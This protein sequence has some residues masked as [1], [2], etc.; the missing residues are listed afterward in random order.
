[1]R[2]L[3]SIAF[4]A[5]LFTAL[6]GAVAH[7]SAL[8]QVTWQVDLTYSFTQQEVSQPD[9][10]QRQQELLG[11][12]STRLSSR[13]AHLAVRRSA[14]ADQGIDDAFHIEGQGTM[15]QFKLAMFDD[16]SL[17]GGFLGGP[18]VMDLTGQVS[19]G[20][21]V[22][23]ALDSN[24]S[25]GYG[26][27]VSQIDPS[28]LQE[29]APPALT[30]ETNLLGAPLRESITVDALQDGSTGLT[31][32]YGRPWETSSSSVRHVSLQSAQLDALTD[33]TNPTPPAHIAMPV[34]SP[35]HAPVVSAPQTLPA[36]FDWR[37]QSTLPPVRDQGS[38]GACWAF[39]TVG[40]METNMAIKTGSSADLSEQYLVSC[41]RDGWGCG[42]GWWA[43]DYHVSESGQHSNPPGAVLES[44]LP[45]IAA[46]TTCSATY[47]HPY[48]LNSWHY[49][50]NS[51]SIPSVTAIKQAIYSYGPVAAAVCAGP[52]FQGYRGGVFTGDDSATCG[53]SLVNHA[54][55]LVGWNDTDN[56]WIL[57]NSWGSRWGES[58]YM[59]LVRNS[60]NVGFAANY[61]VY[62]PAQPT[63]YSVDLSSV[64]TSDG[65]VNRSPSPNCNGAQYSAGTSVTI[66]AVPAAGEHFRQWSGDIYSIANPVTVNTDGN[67]TISANFGPSQIGP[68][69]L[70]IPYIQK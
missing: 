22:Q 42:G 56:T 25:T 21:Q 59:R 19:R 3:I 4:L 61:V 2:R 45:Y 20:Q 34:E 70:F 58:G 41:N 26:W 28:R 24:P 68:A 7:S 38:C 52:G 39:A 55:V 13:G 29:S 12:L 6:S 40:A 51:Y 66:T 5:F 57:R 10:A 62:Q 8:D 16:L 1:M 15:E 49:V 67:K 27:Q 63:C 11:T 65:T 32:V 23:I 44:D 18:T 9:W 35:A 69:S 53:S 64:P 36:S 33:F 31:L 60:S 43:H 37:T 30:S 50:G 48:Q 17:V 54:I 46:D 47:S 14:R